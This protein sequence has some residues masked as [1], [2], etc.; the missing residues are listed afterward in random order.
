MQAISTVLMLLVGVTLSS[1]VQRLLPVPVPLP[2]VQIAM[3]ATL[4]YLAGFDVPLNPEIFFL[5]LVPPLLFLDGRRIPRGAFFAN[6]RPILTLAIGGVVFTVVGIGLLI[7]WLIPSIPLPVASALAAV[8]S[9]T[10]T[11][12]VSTIRARVPL[13]PRLVHIVEGEA[14]LNDASGLVCFRFA[15]AAALTGAFSLPSAI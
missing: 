10:D 11:V 5:L 15:V 4:S 7:A 2:L 6:L 8:L 3:G 9:P 1:F 12:A 14:L 13:A